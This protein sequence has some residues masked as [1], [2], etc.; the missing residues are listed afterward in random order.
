[1]K[2]LRPIWLLMM[3][4]ALANAHP[5][6]PVTGEMGIGWGLAHPFSGVD[7]P[8]TA[9]AVGLWAVQLGKGS[10][11]AL[12][13]AFLATMGVGAALGAAGLQFPMIEPLILSIAVILS[14]LVAFAMRISLKYSAALAG[15]AGAFHGQAHG[16]ELPAGASGL[17]AIAGAVASMA[18]LHGCGMLTGI[19]LQ[20]SARAGAIRVAGAAILSLVILSGLGML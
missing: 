19:A 2:T 1:M 13:F 12:P 11:I 17:A 9:I 10:R 5:G 3:F 6:H 8:L 7:H 18:I 20:H 14:A 16:L 4:P 15:I